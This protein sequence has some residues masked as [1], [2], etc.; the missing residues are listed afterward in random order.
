M[1]DLLIAA[2]ILALLVVYIVYL[3]ISHAVKALYGLLPWV[4]RRRREARQRWLEELRREK[5]ERERQEQQRL[6]NEQARLA[7][8][9]DAK[10]KFE[11]SVLD[12]RFPSEEV[13]TALAQCDSDMPVNT[14]ETL[15]ELL[16]RRC[17]LQSITFCDAVLLIQQRQRI[18][19]RAEARAARD[20]ERGFEPTGPVTPSEA[21]ELLGVNAGCSPE[22]LAAAYHR[23]IGQWHP[24][25][26]NEAMAQE[27]RDYATRRTQRINAA[28]E[29]LRQRA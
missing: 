10:R 18:N 13:L 21:Y 15:G 12:G 17:S 29:L 3:L 28:F 26:L 23:I 4:R 2:G 25:R 9:E 27:L 8:I 11:E 22:E 19:Q 24:D 20:R 7:A 1:A 6:R 5:Q 14:K 16:Y